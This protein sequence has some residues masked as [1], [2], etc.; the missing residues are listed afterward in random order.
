MRLWH[1]PRQQFKVHP[2]AMCPLPLA[3]SHPAAMCPL[4]L[5]LYY[6]AAHFQLLPQSRSDDKQ[7]R[8]QRAPHGQQVWADGA[9]VHQFEG[10]HYDTGAVESTKH[11]IFECSHYASVRS[12]LT[13]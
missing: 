6:P 11:V 1:R 3:L 4:P 5:A 2:S 9:A 10:Q 13:Q 8:R 12:D 7:T